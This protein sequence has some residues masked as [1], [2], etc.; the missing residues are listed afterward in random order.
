MHRN[1]IRIITAT[2]FFSVSVLAGDF[3][4]TDTKFLAKSWPLSTLDNVL[5]P[6]DD[7]Q[8]FPT[9]SNPDGLDAIPQS[10]RAA[11]IA[12]GEKALGE[13]WNPL[14]ATLFL[15]YVRIGNRSRFERAQ[16]G[17]RQQLA[18]LVLA[19][20]FERKGRFMDQIVNG[21]WV[22]CEESFWGVPAHLNGQKA[23][24][25]LPDVTDP[26]VDLFAAETGACFSIK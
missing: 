17:R 10:I 9:A 18:G 7:W 22:V 24:L 26:Y 11:H 6:K 1:I 20:L 21:I 8:P 23:G 25:G 16:F 4:R 13:N 15:E 12:E 5:L 3:D 19:E 2:L 14:P